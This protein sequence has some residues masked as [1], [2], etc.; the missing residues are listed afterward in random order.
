MHRRMN[1][2]LR[3]FITMAP[4]ITVLVLMQFLP[5]RI[6]DVDVLVWSQVCLSF[7]LPFAII[8]LVL[9]TQ[10]KDLMREHRNL[11]LTNVLAWIST[12]IVVGLNLYLLWGFFAG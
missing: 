7:A 11:P 1:V 6:S 12:A 9:F 8:P 5:G 2:F 4:A 3:R 10:R